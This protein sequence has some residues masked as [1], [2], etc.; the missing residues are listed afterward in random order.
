[1]GRLVDG[2]SEQVGNLRMDPG[3]PSRTRQSQAYLIKD[4]A[5]LCTIPEE[6]SEAMEAL[7][8]EEKDVVEIHHPAPTLS[9]VF[10]DY[11]RDMFEAA[12]TGNAL[13][14]FGSDSTF[15]LDGELCD[16]PSPLDELPPALSLSSCS[17]P[18]FRR[19]L[20]PHELSPQESEFPM[21]CLPSVPVC[22]SAPTGPPARFWAEQ[23]QQAA[24]A[25]HICNQALPPSTIP[26]IQRQSLL[27]T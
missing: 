17:K 2:H 6:S 25:E 24:L 19:R 11:V 12:I 27:S 1:M 13:E 4:S 9:S 18:S 21:D 26:D 8:A 16:K 3:Y 23:A 20:R 22:L 10:S 7:L 14:F 15:D 5:E